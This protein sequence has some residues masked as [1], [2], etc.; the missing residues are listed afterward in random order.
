M[1]GRHFGADHTVTASF[2][3][4]NPIKF[5]IISYSNKKMEGSNYHQVQSFSSEY[6]RELKTQLVVIAFGDFSTGSPA[7]A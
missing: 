6:A 3:K 1:L 2:I 5:L 4:K 7:D